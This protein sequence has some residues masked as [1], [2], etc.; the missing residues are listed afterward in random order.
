MRP[1]TRETIIDRRQP[2]TRWSAVL[3]G[4]A[5]AI[6]L[7]ILLQTLGMGLGLAAVDVD[8]AGSLKGVGIGTGIWSI[9]A[10]LIAMF[11]GA[12]VV[13]RLAGTIDRRVGAMHGSVMW[14]LA[15]A[16]G[17]WAM[18]SLVGTMARSVAHVGGAAASVTG[19]V[20]SGAA[21][22]G[23]E[24]DAGDAMSALGLDTNDLIVPINERLAREGKPAITAKQLNQTLKAVAKR[25]VHEGKIDRE[26]LV[27]ELA[28]NTALSRVDAEEIAT[29][30]GAR[31]E[32]LANRVSQMGEKIGEGAKSAALEAA[33]KTG[34]AL[35][36]GGIMMLLSLGAALGGGALG[37][38]ASE[39]RDLYERTRTVVPIVT[40]A[41]STIVT[42]EG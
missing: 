21:R 3:A 15:T 1:I 38:R 12:F 28:S 22:A 39:R 27:S 34:K 42:R 14:A 7:W 31:Y 9:I 30:F 33:D 6:G 19:A 13:G 40:P 2:M 18:L 32:D 35:L 11:I 37:A 26:V 17:L 4:T 20:V 36:L 10:P 25:G 16:V 41:E 8:D 5:L 24:V 29:Q 23:G